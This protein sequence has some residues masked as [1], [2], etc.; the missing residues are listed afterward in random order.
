MIS[1]HLVSNAIMSFPGIP[2][3]SH[4]Y[5]REPLELKSE[6][7]YLLEPLMSPSPAAVQSGSSTSKED[8]DLRVG[9]TG[10]TFVITYVKT[11]RPVIQNGP[12]CGVVALTMAANL[13]LDNKRTSVN[14]K[15]PSVKVASSSSLSETEN[16]PEHVL[17]YARQAGFTK[18]GEMFSIEYMQQLAEHHLSMSAKVVN[19]ESLIKQSLLE[20]LVS[21]TDAVLIP[22]DADKNHTPCQAKGHKAHWCVLVGFA[23]TIKIN[24][25]EQW[26]DSTLSSHEDSTLLECCSIDPRVQGHLVLKEES[27]Q[28][29]VSLLNSAVAADMYQDG[30][31][32]GQVKVE[33]LHVFARHGK[34]RHLGL[35]NIEDLRRSNGN[36]LEV[37]P[38]RT[39]PGEY[40]I[41]EPGG[42]KD[43][44]CG[45]ALIVSI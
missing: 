27:K 29:F 11:I 4:Q 44:L 21:R 10:K 3:L 42:I 38:Q 13:L 41:P 22:Y 28:R 43:G 32:S 45:K 14:P 1:A 40:V 17:E 25:K 7:Q 5:Y 33:C 12:M 15:D 34:S 9:T 18:Q 35:W 30:R 23:L 37:D 6:V 24:Q 2:K 36:L 16:H 20:L 31:R 19:F 26:N 8:L 39:Q